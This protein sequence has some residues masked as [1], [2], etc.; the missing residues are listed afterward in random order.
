MKTAV[1]RAT[2][3]QQ[4][5]IVQDHLYDKKLFQVTADLKHY[6]VSQLKRMDKNSFPVVEFLYA[7][8]REGN[9]KPASRASTIDRLCQISLFHNNKPF[10][11]ITQEDI[12]SYLDTIRKTENEDPLHKWVGTYNISIIKIIS[13]FRWLYQPS[14]HS[15]DRSTPEFL[16]NLRCIKRKEKTTV[17]GKDLWTTE[18]DALFLKYCPDKRLR[19]YHIMA[20]ETS[21]RPHEL[22]SLKIG[23]VIFHNSEGKI[24]ATITIGKEGKTIP[25][26]VPIINSIPY[27]KDWISEHPHGES[28]NH[29][30]FPSLDR[31]FIMRNKK[32]ETHSLNVLYSAMKNKLFPRLL[33]DP[34][35]PHADKQKLKALLQKPINPYLRRHIG[36]T[37]KARQ[38][39]EHSLRIYSGWTKSSKMP[40]VYT[41]ELGDEVSNQ[42]LEL[43]GITTRSKQENSILRSKQCPN[44]SE[45]NKPESK[46]CSSCRMV[47]SYD[48]YVQSV[49]T[50]TNQ[51]KDMFDELKNRMAS[52]EQRFNK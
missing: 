23:D 41:H 25:R 24:Y 43:E 20:R 4:L 44:C 19:F 29:F 2:A 5:S 18:E 3:D 45:P 9:L 22:L 15:N 46:F 26:T 31:K 27:Y 30:L 12:F 50:S 36:I 48:S 40:E 21:G 35:I 13:F 37:E 34:N 14:L 33:E 8:M 39:P 42:I 10:N 17:S 38:I 51:Y 16:N 49:E 32:L 47:L 11:E 7:K 28:K 1:N 52:L 6:R